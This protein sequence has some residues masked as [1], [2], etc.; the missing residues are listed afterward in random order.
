MVTMA[1][2]PRVA[3]VIGDLPP[4]GD[5]A[6][7]TLHDDYV[8]LLD[9]HPGGAA[10]LGLFDE[11]AGAA[12][13]G[14]E[15]RPLAPTKDFSIERDSLSL[16]PLPPPAARTPDTRDAVRTSPVPAG[17]QVAGNASANGYQIVS[18]NVTVA[19]G[20][21][22][23]LEVQLDVDHGPVCVGVL[24]QDQSA[25]L[26]PPAPTAPLYRFSS[27]AN[28]GV[29]VVVANCRETGA[30]AAASLFVI[31]WTR[32]L[33]RPR[34]FVDQLIDGWVRNQTFELPR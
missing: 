18:P 26:M 3:L 30:P 22:I 34:C 31:L 28:T 24:N 10:Y 7:Y 17:L 2:K 19:P 23:A 25:W 11:T 21:T 33:S 27:G 8:D 5:Q 9:R 1:S 32:I 29:H 16:V 12:I 4:E 6:F 15:V 14:V 20:A 13:A